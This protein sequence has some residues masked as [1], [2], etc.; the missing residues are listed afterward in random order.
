M[1]KALGNI[2]HR[3]MIKK[4]SQ[5]FRREGSTFKPPKDTDENHAANSLLCGQILRLPLSDLKQ[6]TFVH[7]TTGHASEMR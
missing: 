1:E 2:Q 6:G 7:F 4:I 3:S 5:Q